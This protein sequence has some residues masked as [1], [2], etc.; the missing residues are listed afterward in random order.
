MKKNLIIGAGQLGSRHL[1]GLLKL[2]Q[3]Q[4]VYVLDPSSGSLEVAEKRANEIGHSHSVNYISDWNKLPKELDLVIVATGA[5]VREKVI[6]QLLLGHKVNKLV[7]EKILFQDIE[8]YHKIGLLLQKTN[9][10]TWVNHPRRMLAHYQQVKKELVK[11]KGKIVFQVVGGNW[12]LACNS[13]HFIDLCSFLSGEVVEEL[14]LDWLDNS[15]HKS[16][17]EGNIEF[18][19]SI[20]G[21]MKDNSSFIITS[22]DKEVS[23]I[24]ISVST[25]SQRWV[26][27]EGS[28]QK[29]I[30]FSKYNGFQEVITSF[31]TEFQSTLTTKIANDLFEFGNSSLPTYEE[32][33]LSHI[34]FI[35]ASIKKYIEITGIETNTC[36]IT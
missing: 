3:K 24:S 25:S 20:K 7:L 18:T 5:N 36:P 26:I 2:T 23:D 21:K 6:T 32:A 19:G 11:A 33:C 31:T 1:Q 9:T 34:P 35:K 28:A 4:V 12:G 13:L 10:P 14:D 29:I 30:H 17:R 16:K 8:S 15:I 22:F 27:Q